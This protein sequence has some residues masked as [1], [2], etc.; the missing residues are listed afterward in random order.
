MI[1]PG[2]ED[3]QHGADLLNRG[4]KIAI[5][6]GAGAWNA[7]EEVMAICD[8]LQAGIATALL[9]KAVL[10]DDLPYSTGQIGLLGTKPSWELM[11]GCDTLLMIGTTRS[12]VQSI[13]SS[14]PATLALPTA[15]SMA[16]Q[17]VK[18]SRELRSVV[19]LISCWY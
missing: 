5:L 18:A 1:L 4:D 19:S 15:K 7:P 17:A 2:P 11:R 10:S 14:P 12:S 9:G 3:L 13:S 8:R 16:R 6:I